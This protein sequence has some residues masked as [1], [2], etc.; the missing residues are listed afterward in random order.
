MVLRAFQWDDQPIDVFRTE[1]RK[2]LTGRLQG[3]WTHYGG[4]RQRRA[5]RVEASQRAT[6]L[7]RQTRDGAQFRETW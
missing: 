3:P 7:N 1:Q 2:L 4:T 6:W 5:G